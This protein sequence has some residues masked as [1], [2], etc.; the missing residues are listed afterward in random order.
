MKT[1]DK[2]MRVLDQFSLDR[3]ELGLSELSRMAD[4]DK[5]AARRLLVAM[6]RYGFIEQRADTRKYRLGHGF[7]R[8][9]RI[10][11][12]TVPLSRIAQDAVDWLVAQ[13]NETAHAGLPGH[14]GMTTIAYRLPKRGHVIQFDPAELLPFHATATGLAYLAFAPQEQ[15]E[16]I[17]SLERRSITATTMT[18]RADLMAAVDRF[19]AQGYA[20]TATSFDADV[21][22]IAMPFFQDR[23]APL[24]SIALALPKG[25]LTDARRADLL[26]ALRQAVARIERELTGL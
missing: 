18:E 24:G 19:R 5:A 8:L 15:A 9:A 17:L 3:P 1:V 6:Q 13:V 2:A 12:A 10:R 21:S 4:L 7:L 23:A 26:P 20:Q 25:D 14:L 22:S 16:A 11:E